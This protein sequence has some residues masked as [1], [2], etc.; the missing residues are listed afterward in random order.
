[1]ALFL[2]NGLFRIA[3]VSLRKTL[4]TLERQKAVRQ[5][6]AQRDGDFL[7]SQR[8]VGLLRLWRHSNQG[9]IHHMNEEV[10]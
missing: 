9:T 5:A 10:H 3:V 6:T 8:A 7:P 1:M 4:R 2:R